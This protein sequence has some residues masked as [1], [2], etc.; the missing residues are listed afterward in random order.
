MDFVFGWVGRSSSF[1][2]EDERSAA[3]DF[4]DGVCGVGLVVAVV[5]I[6][7]DDGVVV[8]GWFHFY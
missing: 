3:V 5:V 4:G 2:G 7:L 6:G 1:E 8:V